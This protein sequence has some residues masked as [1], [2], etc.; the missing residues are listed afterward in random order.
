MQKGYA[1]DK[2]MKSIT[3]RYY[4]DIFNI[5]EVVTGGYF[6]LIP[7]E[8]KTKTWADFA[9][10]CFEFFLTQNIYLENYKY[11]LCLI[12]Y[13]NDKIIKPNHY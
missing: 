7:V 13:Q 9:S 4:V 6:I 12:F 11:V 5:A 8:L 3:V 1:S 2:G 10:S